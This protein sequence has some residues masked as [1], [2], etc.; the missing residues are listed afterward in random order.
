[1]FVCLLVI[2]STI[3][4][5][6]AYLPI[7]T[8]T[9]KTESATLYLPIETSTLETESSIS[10][11]IETSTLKTES[12]TSYPIETPIPETTAFLTNDISTTYTTQSQ[13]NLENLKQNVAIEHQLQEVFVKAEQTQDTNDIFKDNIITEAKQNEIDRNDNDEVDSKHLKHDVKISA[14]LEDT[15][16]K[17]ELMTKSFQK[18]FKLKY[19]ETINILHGLYH[20]PK[21]LPPGV[22][23]GDAFFECTSDYQNEC[24]ICLLYEGYPCQVCMMLVPYCTCVL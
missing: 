8:P 10:Y 14:E 13:N 6:T 12:S 22:S 19:K 7:E 4:Y 23:S 1:M 9:S 18:L 15:K 17:L 3:C 11:P 21:D 2:K 24:Q 16:H 20:Q 5:P